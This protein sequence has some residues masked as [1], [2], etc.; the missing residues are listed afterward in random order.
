[1]A[2]GA[3]LLKFELDSMLTAVAAI[4]GPR[5]RFLACL[6]FDLS[7]QSVELQML[8]AVDPNQSAQPRLKRERVER[9]FFRSAEA[10]LPRMNAGGSHR[11]ANRLPPTG[12]CR[13]LTLF[14]MTTVTRG[15]QVTSEKRQLRHP[16]SDS[17]RVLLAIRARSRAILIGFDFN[18]IKSAGIG[19]QNG[20]EDLRLIVRNRG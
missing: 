12:D 5:V 14:G 7:S 15:V 13:S 6:S 20:E 16:G 11:N 3:P 19:W 17:S 10:L 8:L 4:L 1:M 9:G 18:A 2:G